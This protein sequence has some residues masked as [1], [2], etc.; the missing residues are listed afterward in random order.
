VF[1]QGSFVLYRLFNK[2]DE[3]TPVSNSESPST[4]SQG[5]L[6]HAD[7][8]ATTSVVE[9]GTSPSDLSQLTE[10]KLTK[11]HPMAHLLTTIGD[12][13]QTKDQVNYLFSCMCSTLFRISFNENFSLS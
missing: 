3:E 12:T 6:L 2:H 9:D 5:N 4:P 8:T 13:E 1:V 10:T 7:D 11:V